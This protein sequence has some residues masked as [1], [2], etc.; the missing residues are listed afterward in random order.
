VQ[1]AHRQVR[2]ELVAAP[3]FR[4][5]TLDKAHSAAFEIAGEPKVIAM[6]MGEY[7]RLDVAHVAPP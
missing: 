4:P 3:T 2:A 1:R 6:A 7:E 5:P